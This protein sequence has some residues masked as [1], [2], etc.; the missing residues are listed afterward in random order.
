M[1]RERR[2]IDRGCSAGNEV[3]D[4]VGGSRREQDAVAVVAGG[5][6]LRSMSIEV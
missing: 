5:D 4:D 3:S 6:E 2:E 1:R